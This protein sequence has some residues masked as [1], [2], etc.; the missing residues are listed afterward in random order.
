MKTQTIK[1]NKDNLIGQLMRISSAVTAAVSNGKD[2]IVEIKQERK[3]RSLDANSYYWKLL[4]ELGNVLGR[5]KD[6]LHIEM[7]RDYGQREAFIVASNV[8]VTGYFKYY[9]IISKG[10]K[11]I[12]Y[13]VY[14]PSSEMDSREM[15]ILIEG[16]VQE[17]QEQGIET[18]PPD[19]QARIVS[20][21]DEK[22]KK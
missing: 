3:K 18:L 7:L 12:H 15:S 10:E 2:Y 21:W 4:N 19:E 13:M 16:V 1:I 22:R 9:E 14:K 20:L 8:D 6:E 5:S 17:A 11:F